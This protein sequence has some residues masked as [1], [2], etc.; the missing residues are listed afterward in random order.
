MQPPDFGLSTA[1]SKASFSRSAFWFKWTRLALGVPSI[2]CRETP[3]LDWYSPQV[4]GDRADFV[5][6]EV[7][8]VLTQGGAY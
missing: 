6:L 8:G 2:V 3:L 1:Y 7:I 5:T 4:E